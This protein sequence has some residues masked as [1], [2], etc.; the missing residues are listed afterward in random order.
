MWAMH[1]VLLPGAG[2]LGNEF[3]VMLHNFC[4]PRRILIEGMHSENEVSLFFEM[5]NE[6]EMVVTSVDS[7]ESFSIRLYE[8]DDG[9]QGCFLMV[10]FG[11]KRLAAL[12]VRIIEGLGGRSV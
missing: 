2:G 1:V 4:I 7:R 12:V 9:F 5:K 3:F 8:E 11:K 10:G 6:S